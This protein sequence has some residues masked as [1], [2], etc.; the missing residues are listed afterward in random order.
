MLKNTVQGGSDKMMKKRILSLVLLLALIITTVSCSGKPEN[1]PVELGSPEK[2]FASSVYNSAVYGT[3]DSKKAKKLVEMLNACTYEKYE[4]ELE[5]ELGLYNP[6]DIT[7][8]YKSG[9]TLFVKIYLEGY[10]YYS[11]ETNEN[12]ALYKISGFDKEIFC[13]AIGLSSSSVKDY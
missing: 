3:E 11:Y 13:D 6:W 8:V 2:I 10:T 9:D 1:F 7:F 5:Y 4:Q 12:S